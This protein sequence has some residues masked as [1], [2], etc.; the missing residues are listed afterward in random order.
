MNSAPL[1]TAEQIDR[2]MAGIFSPGRDKRSPEY[3]AGC[4]A[5][6]TRWLAAGPA[7]RNPHPTGSAAADAWWAG[8]DEGR[9]TAEIVPS[10]S[11]SFNTRLTRANGWG[12][13]GQCPAPTYA[14]TPAIREQ[15]RHVVAAG[16]TPAS[17]S[18]CVTCAAVGGG[19]E[20]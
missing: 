3:M 9:S 13:A 7:T 20:A 5:A 16:R 4:R 15:A 8:W 17:A 18:A 6:L 10:A 11:G 1:Y 14:K 12:S 2:L 19:V